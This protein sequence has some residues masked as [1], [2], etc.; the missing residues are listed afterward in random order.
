MPTLR[1]MPIPKATPAPAKAIKGAKTAPR[2]QDT[3]KGGLKT[4][5]KGA[6]TPGKEAAGAREP[7]SG[8]KGAGTGKAALGAWEP[9]RINLGFNRLYSHNPGHGIV[10]DTETTGLTNNSSMKAEDQ[11]KIIE[12]GAHRFS[13]ETGEV[14]ETLN[15][16]AHPGHDLDPNIIRITGIT[17]EDLKDAPPFAA[18]FGKL[19][20]FFLGVKVVIGHNVW[21]DLDL[22]MWE[23]RR[24][25]TE[26][27][28]PWPP[29]QVDTIELSYHIKGYRLN[30]AALYAELFDGETFS[31]HRAMPDVNAC[32]RSY[33]EL[34][35]RAGKE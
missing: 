19:Q 1:K 26:R 34:E 7:K 28:F 17:N 2:K 18:N 16:L 23:L 3:P 33:L 9:S 20:D 6:K 24:M 10:F 15:F 25:N 8:G 4:A 31:A 27:K 13:L 35:R 32:F 11:P 12:F 21:F 22:L 14:L 30:L 5:G 29:R